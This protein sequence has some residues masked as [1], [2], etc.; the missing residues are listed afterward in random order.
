MAEQKGRLEL[1]MDELTDVHG[2]VLLGMHK[3]LQTLK[4][5]VTKQVDRKIK[6]FSDS[7]SDADSQFQKYLVSSQDTSKQLE[8]IRSSASSEI[9]TLKATAMC[10]IERAAKSV[11]KDL[12]SLSQSIQEHQKKLTASLKFALQ[13]NDEGKAT[14]A[15]TQSIIDEIERREA[16][17]QKRLRTTL[18]TLG[19]VST[20]TIGVWIWLSQRL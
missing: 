20:A 17:Y 15:K 2:T 1:M 18:I 12:E 13:L 14:Q 10:D 16:D 9:S 4:Q 3:E 11:K 5:E 19:I 8:S 7:V 6:Q